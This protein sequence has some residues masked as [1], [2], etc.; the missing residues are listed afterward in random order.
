MHYRF[1]AMCGRLSE[2]SIS[3]RAI[4]KPKCLALWRT[5]RGYRSPTAVRTEMRGPAGYGPK[6]RLHPCIQLA[7]IFSA[8][9]PVSL[10]LDTP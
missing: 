9:F 6:I 5:D 10:P 2:S 7:Q 1:G 4:P 3:P 8:C